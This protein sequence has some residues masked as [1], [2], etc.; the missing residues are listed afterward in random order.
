MPF[1]ETTLNRFFIVIIWIQSPPSFITLCISFLCR[2]FHIDKLW[3]IKRYFT[4]V[5][6]VFQVSGCLHQNCGG[7]PRHWLSS[8]FLRQWW[9]DWDV[10]PDSTL[11]DVL[12]QKRH[13]N[14][15]VLDL[16]SH[17][18]GISQER[19]CSKDLWW[20]NTFQKELYPTMVTQVPLIWSVLSLKLTVLNMKSG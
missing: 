14:V 2:Q 7:R 6:G 9:W 20:K 16:I 13:P 4:H 5:P 11:L 1:T 19:I 17:I 15:N 3:N 10:Y 8:H 12:H 18:V